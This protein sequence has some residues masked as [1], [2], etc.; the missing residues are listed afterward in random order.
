MSL[1]ATT[2]E[3][4]FHRCSILPAHLIDVKASVLRILR[5]KNQYAA[6][7]GRFP[8]LPWWAV[9]VLHEMECDCNFNQHLHNGDPLT[10]RT[11]EFPKGRPKSG[12]PPFTWAESAVDAL[13]FNCLDQVT[14]W[15]PGSALA[16]FERYNGLGYLRRGVPSPY[17][18]SFTNQ[19][20]SGKYTSDGNYDP[21]DISDQPGCAALMKFLL[22]A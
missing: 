19:Y 4:Q 16:T 3:E 14:D 10:H 20:R 13:R 12:N 17:L 21:H 7:A 9:G 6:V 5:G 8:H 1:P 22:P 15:S 11:V 2:Y 18:W